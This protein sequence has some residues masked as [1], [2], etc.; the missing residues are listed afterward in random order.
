MPD[1]EKD[2]QD[3][4]KQAP[5]GKLNPRLSA[6]HRRTT[7]SAEHI[8][9]GILNGDR[10]LLSRSITLVES[11]SERHRAV[12]EEIVEA[13]LPHS[14]NSIR[15][16]ITGSPGVGKSTFIEALGQKI[17]ER[18][19]R[20]AVLAIDPTS[21]ISK[22]SILGDKTRMEQLS[23]REEAFI[24]PSP[25]GESLG[26][27][28]QKTRETIILCEAAG[29]DT[30][31]VE[32][33]GV[34]QSETAVH[35][36]VDFFLLLL[37]PGAGDELQG[38]KRG[39]VE[40]ADLL[41]I[42]KA[43]G[44][45][46]PPAKQAQQEYRNALHLSPPKESGWTPEVLICSALENEG[47]VD[48]WEKVTAFWSSTVKNGYFEA[49]RRQQARYWLHERVN[50]RLRELFYA[51]PGVAARWKELEQAVTDHRI[52]PFKAAD[53]LIRLFTGNIS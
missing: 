20:V 1:K 27:V 51:H 41:V 5:A 30:I 6:Q 32:T 36:M 49:H 28:S 23:Q 9:D 43:E 53:E 48:I 33:V 7:P 45:R 40:M 4:G 42:N 34:G 15:M 18:G 10:V 35:S 52:S 17:I 26:G 25:A 2:K 13:C 8:I 16:G 22:G 12:A 46:L 31:L 3:S 29:F 14:G 38:I 19:R 44:K 21:Q 50:H 24:R 47:I 37:L 39:I 11:H